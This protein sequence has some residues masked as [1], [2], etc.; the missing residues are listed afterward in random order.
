[1]RFAVRP[2]GNYKSAFQ[3]FTVKDHLTPPRAAGTDSAIGVAAYMAGEEMFRVGIMYAIAVTQQIVL[4]CIVESIHLI[5]PTFIPQVHYATAAVIHT[6]FIAH[7]SAEYCFDSAS[8]FHPLIRR[9][10]I[11]LV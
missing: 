1:M 11:T 7:M 6:L 5:V 10:D 2:S 8:K 3:L 9:D 4:S